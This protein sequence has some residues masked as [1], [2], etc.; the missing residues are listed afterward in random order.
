VKEFMQSSKGFAE[1][2][3][4]QAEIEKKEEEY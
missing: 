2:L 1:M 4:E 3:N